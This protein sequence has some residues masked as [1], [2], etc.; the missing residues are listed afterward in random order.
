MHTIAH[1]FSVQE[2]YVLE[3]YTTIQKGFTIYLRRVKDG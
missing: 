2:H 3:H 1:I